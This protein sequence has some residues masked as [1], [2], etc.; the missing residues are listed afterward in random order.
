MELPC[1]A[2]MSGARRWAEVC[3]IPNANIHDLC[4]P[5]TRGEDLGHLEIRIVGGDQECFAVDHSGPT[6]TPAPRLSNA[7]ESLNALWRPGR[8]IVRW[9][10]G[11]LRLPASLGAVPLSQST[12]ANHDPLT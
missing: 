6:F 2:L 11:A 3:K 4:L 5:Q 10:K 7:V 1:V 12:Q 9:R 8:G